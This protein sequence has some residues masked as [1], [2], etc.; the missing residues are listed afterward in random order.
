MKKSKF[1][2][3]FSAAAMAILLSMTACNR[4][5]GCPATDAA[6]NQPDKKG[7]YK[8]SKTKSGLFPKGVYKGH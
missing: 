8:K 1:F 5:S 4:G 7:N 3:V 6:H 2:L